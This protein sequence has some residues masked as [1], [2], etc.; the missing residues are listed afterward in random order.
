[1]PPRLAI[2]I[3]AWKGE[4]LDA[5]LQSL[6]AQTCKE[7]SVYLGDDAS[8]EG[9]HSIV[10]KYAAT[11]DIT[12]R[13]FDQNLGGKDLAAQWGRCVEMVWEEEFFC[14]FSDDDLME[15]G[16]VEA[17]YRVLET[18]GGFDVY[19]WDLRF[20]D[21]GGKP[22][23]NPPLY[24][25]VLSVSDFY[26]MLY[27]G[28]IEARMPE[29]IFRTKAFRTGGGLVEFDSAFRTDNATVM[30][31]GARGIR[32]IPGP[33]VAWRHS[34]AN[35]STQQDADT[36]KRMAAATI[37]FFNWADDLFASRG[38]P[39]PLPRKRAGKI[40]LSLL[41]VSAE[42][43]DGKEAVAMLRQVNWLKNNTFRRWIYTHRLA[44]RLR[45]RRAGN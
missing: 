38:E 39:I 3:P 10:E 9:L 1:M 17:F 27:T 26:A 32:T 40:I 6:A 42:E 30:L 29:F 8:P 41:C 45:E 16:C 7:F 18:D 13:R 36:A 25:E 21:G 33:R 44:R 19:R 2:V 5:T 12:Y 24:P 4:F 37:R 14:L 22:A 15:P 35:L 20:I 43:G 23:E 34:A 31:H 11:L 28:R